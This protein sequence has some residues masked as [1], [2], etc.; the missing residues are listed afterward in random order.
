MAGDNNNGSG[1]RGYHVPYFFCCSRSGDTKMDNQCH[2]VFTQSGDGASTRM[3]YMRLC[4]GF[5]LNGTDVLLHGQCGGNL[6]FAITD[7]VQA[8][9]L[10]ALDIYG[11]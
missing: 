11:D 3:S 6:F 4:M 5:I 9:E 10:L 8:C 2:T 7:Y 1:C